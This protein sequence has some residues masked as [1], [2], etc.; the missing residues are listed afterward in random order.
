[1]FHCR[2]LLTRERQVVAFNDL[3]SLRSSFLLCRCRR[4]RSFSSSTNKPS[5]DDKETVDHQQDVDLGDSFR[6]MGLSRK[7]NMS[8]RELKQRYHKLMTEYHPDKH[9]NK[10]QTERDL[11]DEKA[12][13]VT[14]A[15]QTLTQPHTRATHLLELLGNP[16]CIIACL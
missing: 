15:F 16:V 11:M 2:R 4:S 14:H 12:A 9:T 13:I 6:V 8:Q 3:S 5:D 7:F 1:M 10:S